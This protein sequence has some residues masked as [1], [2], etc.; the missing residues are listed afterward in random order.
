MDPRLTH[1][2]DWMRLAAASSPGLL[3]PISG[4]SDSA[5]C[6]WICTRALPKKVSAVYFGEAL[7]ARSWFEGLGPV[8]IRP[9]PP[10]N[11]KQREVRRWMDL[12]ELSLERRCWLV[13]SRNR[14]EEVFGSYSIA[15]RVIGCLPLA[16]LWK[17]EVMELCQHVGVPMEVIASS[18]RADP[19]CG[20]PQELAEI[21]LELI[22]HFLRVQE[23]E[24]PEGALAALS[25]AQ[26][27]YLE[28]VHVQNRF[29]RAL[30]T[31]APAF[32]KACPVIQPI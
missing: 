20:R 1:L 22:D 13:G 29:K 10:G 12:L 26:V 25:D 14:T 32:A 7:L 4:G 31:R 2:I 21:G 6:F 3:I 18:R 8:E 19:N 30:P 24:L 28:N 23:G 9:S 27:R 15:S 16:G 5:L 17:S 11:P